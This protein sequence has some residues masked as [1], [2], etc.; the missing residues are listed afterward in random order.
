MAYFNDS[1]DF[2]NSIVDELNRI[3]SKWEALSFDSNNSY[4]LKR[5]LNDRIEVEHRFESKVEHENRMDKAEQKA[6]KLENE[7]NEISAFVDEDKNI[8]FDNTIKTLRLIEILAKGVNGYRTVLKRNVKMSMIECIKTCLYK[9]V[10]RIF[11]L[12]DEEYEEFYDD[13]IEYAKEKE[14]IKDGEDKRKAIELVN[15]IVTNVLYEVMTTFILNIFSTIA[16]ISSSKNTID[17]V[18]SLRDYDEKNELIFDNAFLKFIYRIQ[19]LNKHI[20]ITI[21]F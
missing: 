21:S 14:L 20:L 16:S 9:I 13:V 19:I 15:K 18:M 4:I 3:N 5:I 2:F 6:I 11:N 12:S 17:L 8:E 1:I 10:Y 7:K